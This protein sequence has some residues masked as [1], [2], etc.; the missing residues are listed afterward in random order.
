M[1]VVAIVT[2]IVGIGV[3]WGVQKLTTE[4]VRKDVD[5]V[6]DALDQ[7]VKTITTLQV[8]ARFLGEALSR[9]NTQIAVLQERVAD[10]QTDV[11]RLESS[12]SANNHP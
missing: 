8:E 9:A 4:T 2:V 10:L 3:A 11:I 1:P 6:R 7:A 12:R 5:R